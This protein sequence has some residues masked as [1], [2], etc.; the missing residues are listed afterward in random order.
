MAYDN[1]FFDI[2]RPGCIKSAEVV[3]PRVIEKLGPIKTVIDVGCGEGW[4]ANEFKKYGAEATGIDNDGFNSPSRA[5]LDYWHQVDMLYGNV[6]FTGPYDLAICLE[7]VE[8]LPE[9]LGQGLIE[10][11]CNA[12]DNILFSAA[13]PMQGGTGHINEQ[14][15]NY[16][17]HKFN[18]LGYYARPF[19]FEFW[20]NP[21]VEPWYQQNMYLVKKLDDTPY[22]HQNCF[23]TIHPAF[24]STR[25]GAPPA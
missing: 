11:L 4:W 12:S 8:H 13:I 17:I 9:H 16:W 25:T 7:V 24:W 1:S 5:E 14:W 19:G 18:D 2:I 23:P 6:W 15:P 20:G 10:A 21:D 22:P 3:V